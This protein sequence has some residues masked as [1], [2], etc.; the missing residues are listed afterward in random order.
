[1]KPRRWDNLIFDLDGTLVDSLPGIEASARY[2]VEN[3][4]PG[5]SLPELR[6]LIGPPIRT[7][8]T[9]LWPE[10]DRAEI[11]ALVAVFRQHYDTEGCL[12]SRLYPGVHDT[13]DDLHDAGM[14]MFV[15]T[16]KLSRSADVILRKTGIRQ[17][18]L[19]VMSP[20]SAEPPYAVKNEGAAIL[21]IRYQ[22]VPGRTLLMGDGVNDL[23]AAEACGFVF[24]AAAYGYGNAS[25]ASAPA[26]PPAQTFSEIARLML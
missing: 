22:L 2:A 26:I 20:D 15:L 11:E 14:A 13:L 8:F 10:R 4:L 19:D 7:M 21:Q 5:I 23:E 1:M 6:G 25:Q 3:C 24:V 18:F 16:N 12:L 9:Q 17:F